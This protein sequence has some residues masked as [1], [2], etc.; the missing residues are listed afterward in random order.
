MNWVNEQYNGRLGVQESGEHLITFTDYETD[1]QIVVYAPDDPYGVTMTVNGQIISLFQSYQFI[2][3]AGIA[4]RCVYHYVNREHCM[5]LRAGLTVHDAAFSSTPHE[6]E[7]N[8]EPG[9]E[10]CFYF[11]TTGKGLLEGEGVWPD[12]APVDAAWPIRDRCVAQVPMGWHRVVALPLE[13]GIAP[14]LFYIWCY[15]CL[16]ERW[17]KG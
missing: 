9:F 12:G 14:S 10:E 13:D 2:K 4:Q 11:L 7:L 3:G 1:E 6:F 15:L 8:P 17:E 5:A 16:H